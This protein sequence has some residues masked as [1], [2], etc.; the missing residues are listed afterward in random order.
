MAAEV[1]HEFDELASGGIGCDSRLGRRRRSHLALL[2]AE[3]LDL[4]ATEAIDGLLRIAYGAQ[5]ALP[6]ARQIANQIDLHLVGILELIDHDHL[7]AALIGGSDGGI[8]AQRLVCHAQQIVIV[9]RGLVG[10][11]RTVL[12]LH[13]TG[14]PHQCIE[15]RTATGKHDI[16]KRIG[17]LGL[18]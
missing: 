17:G 5:R 4:G 2:T 18:E 10:L 11:E 9:E 13:S 8:I 14:K 7:K 6:R 16:D 1:A 3:Y 15:R 12:R